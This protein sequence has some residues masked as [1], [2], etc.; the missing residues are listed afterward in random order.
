MSGILLTKT[1]T[2]IIGPVATLLGYLMN[3]IFNILDKIGIPNIGLSIIIFVII[4]YL[5]MMPLTIKQQKFS[6][7][8]A[9]MSPELQAI[10]KKYEGKRDNDSI[11]AMNEEQKEVYKKYGV[12][13]TGSCVQLLIQMPI[14]LALYRVI[15]NIPAYVPAVKNVFSDLVDK[16]VTMDG[17]SEFLQTF[18]NASYYSKQF[19][20]EAFAA[21]GEVMRN[22]F[23]DVLNKASTAE[24]MSIGDKFSSLSSIVQSTYDTLNQYN[25]FLGLNIGNSPWYTM[26]EAF[27]AGQYLL[28]IGAVLV[29]ILAA[30]SQFLN[31]KLMPQ[32]ANNNQSSGN[33]TADTMMQSM[34]MMNYTMPIMS[35]VLCF[36]LPAGMGIYW[37]A[38]SV[39]RCIQ[40]VAINKHIDKIDFDELIKK[41]QEKAAKKVKKEVDSS[42]LVRNANI[43]AKAATSYDNGMSQ[44]E[45]DALIEEA[46]R[47]NMNAKP[48]SMAAKV[49]MVKDYNEKNSS[50]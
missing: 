38:G 37:V 33:E 43:R 12:S 10:A 31:V 30:L 13:P 23:I 11:M 14:L 17:A 39:V 44:K 26:K 18:N 36:T 15:Y 16:L 29:P 50:K 34:K 21:G 22:T 28:V 46:K 9:K 24:W 40:Q 47:K 32:A 48:E 35:A 27:G 7:L 5:C 41:N 20:S 1:S 2:F 4:I 19:E 42:V 3:G 8:Q 25:N 45:K 6:K 49:N